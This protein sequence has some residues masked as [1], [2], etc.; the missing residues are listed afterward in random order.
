MNLLLIFFL[1]NGLSCYGSLYLCCAYR[2]GSHLF[3]RV[4]S[5][6]ACLCCARLRRNHL[7]FGV[8]TFVQESTAVVMS[9]FYLYR[10]DCRNRGDVGG[11]DDL[12]L[13]NSFLVGVTRSFCFSLF[14]TVAEPEET[15]DSIQILIFVTLLLN[16]LAF[17][18]SLCAYHLYLILYSYL[19]S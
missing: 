7:F 14:L 19:R 3:H 15:L 9:V 11:G 5:S 16:V 4:L 6:G 2:G 13:L 8:G 10:V 18:V 12:C 17:Q 1:S